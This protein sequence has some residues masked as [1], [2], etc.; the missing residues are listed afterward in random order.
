MQAIY[1]FWYGMIKLHRSTDASQEY[2][3]NYAGR[4]GKFYLMPQIALNRILPVDNLTLTGSTR[5][6]SQILC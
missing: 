5:V 3:F 1:R 2:F 6:S 4:P